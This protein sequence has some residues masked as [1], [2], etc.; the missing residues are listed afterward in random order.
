MKTVCMALSGCLVV[1][2]S[3][4]CATAGDTAPAAGAWSV[5]DRANEDLPGRIAEILHAGKPVAGLVYGEGQYKPYLAVYDAE[6]RRLTNPGLTPEGKTHGQFPHHRGIFIGWNRIRSDLGSDDLW[7]L[8]KKEHMRVAR[9]EKLEA[10]DKGARIAAR[11]EW[12]SSRR[13]DAHEGVLI[14]ELRTIKVSRP[15]GRT[16]IDHVSELQAVR[17]LQL[18]GDLQHAGLHFRTDDAMNPQRASTRYLWS[19][20]GLPPGG[21]RVVSDELQWVHFR[22]PLH[23]QWYAVTQLNAPQNKVTELSWRDYG[24]FGFFFSGALKVGEVRTM[25]GRFLIENCGDPAQA[26]E[27]ALRKQADRDYAAYNS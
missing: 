24:R 4:R 6:G 18:D 27:A 22:F 3:G 9:F 7:H 19:P 26:D 8:N 23:G 5:R 11:I 16:V 21:G 12:V 17:D 25:R 15:G 2:M 14:R 10:T 1:L 13:D 20:A